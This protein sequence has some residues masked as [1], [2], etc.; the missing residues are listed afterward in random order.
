MPYVTVYVP[1]NMYDD[2]EYYRKVVGMSKSKFIQNAI[3]MY[4]AMIKRATAE[5]Y[6]DT[7]MRAVISEIQKTIENSLEKK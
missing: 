4:V 1:R 3:K 6:I 7:I 2:I 5:E